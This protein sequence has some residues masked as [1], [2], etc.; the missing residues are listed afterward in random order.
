MTT[1]F[2]ADTH[3]GH[4]NIIH[5]ANRP[6]KTVRDMD[7]ELIKRWNARVTKEDVVYHLGDFAFL[8]AH[9]YANRLNGKKILIRGNHD[10]PRDL[11]S[12]FEGIYEMYRLRIDPIE[13]GLADIV[14][15]T[16]CHY[17]MRVWDKSHF[18]SWHFY[19][20]SHGQLPPEGKSW[21]VG[22]DTNNYEPKTITEL[23]QILL[24]R[25]DNINFVPQSAIDQRSHKPS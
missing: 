20:H 3:F 14:E 6:F 10:R 12:L 11:Q 18:N 5:Y 4:R 17:A 22:V 8:D 25:P 19:G 15:I 13:T 2:T 21:D 23:T 24:T 16:L 7:E 1:F 9:Y